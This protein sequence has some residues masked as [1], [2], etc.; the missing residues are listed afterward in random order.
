M[1]KKGLA[2]AEKTFR[3]QKGRREKKNLGRGEKGGGQFEILLHRPSVKKKN[4]C[5]PAFQQKGGG[6]VKERFLR[7]ESIMER[8][9]S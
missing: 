8:A 4:V 5:S 1:R 2:Q 7:T 6:E 3:S 9:R